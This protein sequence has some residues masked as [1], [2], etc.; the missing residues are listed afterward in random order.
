[1]TETR[2]NK[3]RPED[4][5]R[6]SKKLFREKG[7]SRTTM[8]DIAQGLDIQK[9]SLYYHIKDKETLLFEIIDRTMD[10]IIKNIYGLELDCFPTKTK[11]RLI[12]REHFENMKRYPEELWLLLNEGDKLP[13]KQREILEAKLVKYE[14]IFLEIIAEGIS[15]K[16]FVNHNKHLVA[17]S[18]LG[19]MYWFFQ[20]ITPVQLSDE[21]L[22]EED[23][24]KLFLNGLECVNENGTPCFII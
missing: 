10:L 23:F 16:T 15:T 24:F 22:S 20:R 9:G 1:M 17:Y 14:K 13:R 8:N 12:I 6:K 7:Y 4:I 19:G 3:V 11:L 2:N 21:R 5:Y 18:L